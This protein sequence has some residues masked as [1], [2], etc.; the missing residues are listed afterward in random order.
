MN[1]QTITSIELGQVFNGQTQEYFKVVDIDY[2]LGEATTYVYAGEAHRY[3]R[4]P[5]DAMIDRLNAALDPTDNCD[6]YWEQDHPEVRL[7]TA[8]PDDPD[9]KDGMV[10]H[11]GDKKFALVDQETGEILD[12]WTDE[13]LYSDWALSD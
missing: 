6:E 12:Q 11:L 8:Y 5:I 2:D 7:V 9:Y 3:E 1:Y 10:I 4:G 13:E